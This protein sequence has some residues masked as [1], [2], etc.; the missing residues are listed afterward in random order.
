MKIR[1]VSPLH[2]GNGNQLLDIDYVYENGKV[3]VVDYD[4]AYEKGDINIKR[5]L[6][7]GIFNPNQVKKFVKYELDA[8]CTIPRRARINELIKMEH[9]IYIPGS[10]VKGAI[11]TAILWK[12]LKDKNIKVKSREMLK[13]VERELFGEPHQDFMKFFRVADSNILPI[14]NAAVYSIAILTEKTVNGKIKLEPKPFSIIVEC[15]KP[16]VEFDID[17]ATKDKRLENWDKVVTEFSKYVLE[18]EKE[19]F[20]AR[21]DGSLDNLINWIEKLK[22]RLESGEI[23]LRIGFGTGWL[24][25]TVGSLLSKEERLE[26]GYRLG[27][28]RGRRGK[29]FPKTRRVIVEKNKFSSLPSWVEIK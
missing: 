17:I 5:M 24:W 1:I 10:S 22:D 23:L 29:D 2:I 4:L 11:R 8:Y 13:R 3:K 19:F 25:K 6:E 15:I 18:I 20:K 14:E 12:Y 7:R 26:V 21:N 28:N 9:G 27:L 16:R